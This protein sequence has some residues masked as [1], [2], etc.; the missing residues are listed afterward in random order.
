[1][2]KG[3]TRTNNIRYEMDLGQEILKSLKEEITEVEY[4]RY[5]KQLVYDVKK[6]TSGLAL[7]YAPNA[8]ISNWIKNKYTEKIAHLFEVKTGSKVT[9]KITMKDQV[10]NKKSKKTTEEKIQHSLLNPSHTFDNFIVGGSNQFAYSAVKS[11]SEKAGAVYNPLFIYGGVGLGKTH[12]MQ[13][14]GNVFQNQGKV[15]IYTTVEQFLNDFI[16]HVRNKTMER[17][18]EKYRKCDVLLIDD[19]QFL[20]NKEGIQEE[21]FHTFEALKGTGKQIIL[22]ADKHPKKI[23]GLEKR[24]QSRFEW[25]LVADIQ[26]PELETKIAIVEN[27]CQINKV[28]LSKDIINYIAT[29]IDSNVREIEG[30]LSKL[31]AYSQLMHVDIDLAFT[32][33]VLKD[34]L[35]ENRA[36]LTLDIITQQVSKDLNIKPSEIRSKGRSKN[37]VYARRIAI[38]LCREL[39][40]NTMPQLAQ[41]F[42]MKDHTAISHTLRKISELIQNDEDFKVK[43]EELTNKITSS[44]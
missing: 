39:T 43:I 33:N 14:A 7:F 21:F 34:Q 38:Y 5:I 11:V 44:S 28:K 9:V 42:G 22:T 29:V 16:R 8:L 24:L 17:F 25:G 6:S 26:P 19:I 12:L 41:Y 27:K 2:S 13:A 36:N 23:A 18:Q 4:N 20:S 3:P 31:H 37:L 1:M 32:K 10:D 30:I 35:Q 40:Q 15:V